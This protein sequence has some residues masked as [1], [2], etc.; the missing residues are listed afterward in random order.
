[1]W[2]VLFKIQPKDQY[3]KTAPKMLFLVFFKRNLHDG[4]EAS[5]IQKSQVKAWEYLN[6]RILVMF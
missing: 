6:W 5:L 3:N 4:R 2:K 1:M